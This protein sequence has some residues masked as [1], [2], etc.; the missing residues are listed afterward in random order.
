MNA[1]EVLSKARDVLAERGWH[2]GDFATAPDG[3]VCAVGACSVAAYGM[4]TM[5]AETF[6]DPD[7]ETLLRLIRDVIC[8]SQYADPMSTIAQWNDDPS[9]TY[10]DVV[11]ALKQAEE[12]AVERGL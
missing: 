7:G 12:L 2:Q 10:E 6:G 11:L 9:R 4:P 3:A 8:D 1:A 5:I